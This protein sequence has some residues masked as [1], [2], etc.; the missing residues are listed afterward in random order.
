M[1]SGVRGA[2]YFDVIRSDVALVAANA[3][4]NF[5]SERQILGLS[6]DTAEICDWFYRQD[7]VGE[8][9]KLAEYHD[10]TG[11][12]ASGYKK[13]AAE[14][15][16]RRLMTLETGA[17]I[18]IARTCLPDMPQSGDD[19][20][21]AFRDLSDREE[22]RPTDA[23]Q[24]HVPVYRLIDYALG[25]LKSEVLSSEPAE[26]LLVAAEM[27]LAASSTRIR[28]DL[29]NALDRGAFDDQPDSLR[30]AITHGATHNRLAAYVILGMIA[31]KGDEPMASTD[32][33][34]RSLEAKVLSTA[35]FMCDVDHWLKPE[36]AN[37]AR[38]DIISGYIDK[39][40][41]EFTGTNRLQLHLSKQRVQGMLHEKMWLL[42]AL[43][44]K[45]V[46]SS[47]FNVFP[48]L[49]NAD[50]PI[51][52][53]P[54][55]NRGYDFYLSYGRHGQLIQLKSSKRKTKEYHPEILVKKDDLSDFSTTD[56]EEKLTLYREL[57]QKNYPK[58]LR[59]RALT[60]MLPSVKEAVTEFVA[61]TSTDPRRQLVS[62]VAQNYGAPKP[63]ALNRQQ[64]RD[65][66]FKRKR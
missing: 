28:S 11:N 29:Q 46:I 54:K 21:R 58:A 49:S 30:E 1:K 47:K 23:K 64:R 40:E 66:R 34:V 33:R 41:Q 35:A 24:A 62:N 9:E 45:R 60:A 5:A 43:I 15:E 39:L 26:T 63:S 36:E 10:A 44:A 59:E 18:L 42:D 22:G 17:A 32:A 13:A 48:S 53:K 51:I 55:L 52:N 3:T 4:T 25:Q 31:L 16:W 14:R 6:A 38:E 37:E 19:F 57:I 61:M 20:G 8:Y 27:L 12:D 2:N 65:L 7:P 50:R 56:L